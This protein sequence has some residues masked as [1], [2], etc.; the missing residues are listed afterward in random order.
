MD[1]LSPYELVGF[2]VTTQ[3]ASTLTD[4]TFRTSLPSAEWDEKG[5]TWIWARAFRQLPKELQHALKTISSELSPLNIL[6]P[7]DLESREFYL[8]T[9]IACDEAKH[10]NDDRT[11]LALKK[12]KNAA[13][14]ANR[15]P[16]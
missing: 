11:L 14:K 13:A 8:A 16:P 5:L 2:A 3:F 10:G 1:Y 15:R 12:T 4:R 9:S 7:I 6:V